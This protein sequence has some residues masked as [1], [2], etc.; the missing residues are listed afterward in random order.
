ME[1]PL[2]IICAG[3]SI[4][5]TDGLISGFVGGLDRAIRQRGDHILP[6]RLQS[7][8]GSEFRH[9][10]LFDKAGLMLSGV[11]SSLEFDFSGDTLFLCQLIR[12]TTGYAEI[13]V[14][15]DG[16]VVDRFD[17]R[18]PTL[19]QAVKTFAADGAE[20]KFPLDRPFTYAHKVYVDGHLKQGQISCH[21]YDGMTFSGNDYLVMRSLNE[22]GQ[23]E[24]ILCFP[25]PPPANSRIEVEFSYGE[26]I[27]YT[28]CTVGENEQGDME[29]IYGYAGPKP[30]YGL[31]FRYTNP[32]AFRRIALPKAGAQRIRM[33]ITGGEQPYFVF[34]FAAGR[35]INIVNAGI[36]GW[37]LNF[38]QEDGRGRTIDRALSL[39][40]PDVM[41][42]EYSANDDWH[43]FQRKTQSDPVAMDDAQITKLPLLE[44]YEV[45]DHHVRYCAAPILELTPTSLRCAAMRAVEVGDIARIGGEIREISGVESDRIHWLEPLAET[46]ASEVTIRSLKEYKNR[47]R[48]LITRIR[49]EF[50]Q[51]T[52]FLTAPAPANYGRRQLWGYDIALRQLA[53][54]FPDCRVIEMKK[55][56]AS[57]QPDDWTEYEFVTDGRREYELP[58]SG[59]SQYFSLVPE[60]AFTVQCTDQF[61][62]TGYHEFSLDEPADIDPR[63]QFWKMNEPQPMRLIFTSPPPAG[64][65]FRIRCS[66]QGWSHDYCHPNPAGCRI[67]VDAYTA[68]LA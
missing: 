63:M 60:Y 42:L 36:G 64:V 41:F 54:E 48:R 55:Y 9:F 26:S 62:L 21:D 50:P 52:L 20:T 7:C 22:A 17:N 29:S 30:N 58:W 10:K 59:Y 57:F 49:G 67:Y 40:A 34:N 24:H 1:K 5:W 46:T 37:K 47:F 53:A 14:T 25:V 6:H 23:V 18:N 68:G 13:E 8:G 35:M 56:F 66:T 44:L 39:F 33:E 28:A 61:E 32:A 51:V 2:N 19:G 65:Q 11:G 27:G 16:A 43:Y 31:D 45:K 4:T 15:A 12:R 3:S 38:F